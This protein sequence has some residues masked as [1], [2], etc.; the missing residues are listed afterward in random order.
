MENNRTLK[1]AY[2]LINY[3][4][5]L[6]EETEPERS[7]NSEYFRASIYRMIVMELHLAIESLLQDLIYSVLPK[8]RAFSARQNRSYVENLSFSAAVDLAAR[9]G[10][11]NKSGYEELARLN[12]IRNRTAHDWILGTF[13]MNSTKGRGRSRRYKVEFNGKDLFRPEI[14]KHEFMP[15]YGDIYLEFFAVAYGFR[16][17]RQYIYY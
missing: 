10:I 3:F 2:D 7:Y 13:K 9:L 16:H 1:E 15:H 12:R 8:R 11:I 14:F 4:Y 5:R 6:D 17:K